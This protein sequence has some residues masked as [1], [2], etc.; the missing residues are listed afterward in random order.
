MF[1]NIYKM[2]TRNILFTFFSFLTFSISAQGLLLSTE[3]QLSGVEQYIEEDRGYTSYLPDYY[4]LEKFAPNVLSQGNSSSCVGWATCYSA[5]SI[6]HN[7]HRNITNEFEKKAFPFDPYF[8][9]SIMKNLDKNDCSAGLNIPTAMDFFMEWGAK[10]WAMTPY[11]SCDSKWGSDWLD[12]IKFQSLPFTIDDYKI[13][14]QDD[15]S[16]IKKLIYDGNPIIIAA[17][18]NDSFDDVG[19]SS[20]GTVD[21]NGVW[22]PDYTD[23]D[24]RSGHA[25]TIVA[26]NDYKFG[27]AI[28]VMNSWGTDFG[29][30][31]YVWIKYEDIPSIIR[32]AYI[33][34]KDFNSIDKLPFFKFG[35]YQS[36]DVYEGNVNTSNERHGYGYY[37]WK[38]GDTYIGEWANSYRD[39]RGLFFDFGNRIV[40]IVE[41][42]EGVRTE[43]KSLGFSDDNGKSDFE[44]YLENFDIGL[45]FKDAGP[46]TVI[47][48]IE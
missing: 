22:N 32:E 44:I 4:S 25:M 45:R 1:L 33:L 39:G 34:E 21:K 17:T 19:R 18:I 2:T 43:I 42:D 41:Y 48:D 27:G 5:F 12:E 10:R 14:D 35:K 8:M 31:G 36:G 23:L 15:I 30:N 13:V 9:Y 29:D 6:L 37:Q 28:K 40:Y 46:S 11:L 38:D 7:I 26:Y 47:P 3:E 16:L 20:K 24:S